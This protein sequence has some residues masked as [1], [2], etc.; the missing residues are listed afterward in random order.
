M[1]RAAQKRD[2][3]SGRAEEPVASAELSRKE[4]RE[5]RLS[6]PRSSK[7]KMGGITI[8][9][10]IKCGMNYDNLSD[11]RGQFLILKYMLLNRHQL[12]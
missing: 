11:W 9:L 10:L 1:D 4:D 6:T 7:R 2:G 8:F 12:L 5:E 3:Q